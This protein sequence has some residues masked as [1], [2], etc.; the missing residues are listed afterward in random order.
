[1]GEFGLEMKKSSRPHQLMVERRGHCDDQKRIA[2]VAGRAWRV[3]RGHPEAGRNRCNRYGSDP[4]RTG[5]LALPCAKRR[6]SLNWF[7]G[8]AFQLAGEANSRQV[9]RFS[10][11]PA[12]DTCQSAA[13]Q[14]MSLSPEA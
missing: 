2:V 6:S 9:D 8:V 1:V 5:R 4:G 14:D 3:E 11:P 10:I 13:I 12:K 7:V